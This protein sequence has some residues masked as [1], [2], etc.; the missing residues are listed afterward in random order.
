MPR[1][2]T[3][4][5]RQPIRCYKPRD[6]RKDSEALLGVKQQAIEAVPELS[7]PEYELILS[8][9][10]KPTSR[11]MEEADRIIQARAKALRE[12]ARELAGVGY[13]PE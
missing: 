10:L 11:A 13:E 4:T 3:R 6:E 1:N 5:H 8:A 7:Q 9:D 2:Q 12:K